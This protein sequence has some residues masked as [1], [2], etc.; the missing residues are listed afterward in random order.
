[1]ASIPPFVGIVCTHQ[2]VLGTGFVVD[3]EGKLVVTAA[4]VV[5]G[6]IGANEKLFFQLFGN[7][8]RYEIDQVAAHSATDIALLETLRPIPIDSSSLKLVTEVRP[9][10]DVWIVGYTEEGQLQRD[11]KSA[12]GKFMGPTM[13]DGVEFFEVE[14]KA[15]YKGMSGAPVMVGSNVIGVQTDR[16]S[17]R[18]FAGAL[19]VPISYVATLDERIQTKRTKY[20]QRLI[21]RLGNQQRKLFGFVECF[22]TVAQL[23]AEKSEPKSVFD[24]V[25]EQEK[26]LLVGPAGSGKSTILRE[27]AIRVAL[28]ALKDPQHGVPVFVDLYH[29]ETSPHSFDKFLQ[30]ILE[31]ESLLRPGDDLS[32]AELLAER[33]FYLFLDT[34]DELSSPRIRLLLDWVDK[35]DARLVLTSR[36]YQFPGLAT[37][38][39]PVA[40]LQPLNL[41]TVFEFAKSFFGD[42]NLA[43]DF[44]TSLGAAKSRY[45]SW[46][47]LNTELAGNPFYLS[48]VMESH[49]QDPH[50]SLKATYGQEFTQ[51]SVF[52]TIFKQ[53]WHAPRVVQRLSV[54]RS[55]LKKY[56]DPYKVIHLLSSISEYVQRNALE[57][58]V[59]EK[60]LGAEML[61]VLDESNIL[62]LDPSDNTYKFPHLLFVDFLRASSADLDGIDDYLQ[63]YEYHQ[64]LILLAT[65]GEREREVIQTAF[66]RALGENSRVTD[67]FGRDWI[68]DALGDIGDERAIDAIMNVQ[69]QSETQDYDRS[70]HDRSIAIAKIANRLADQNPHKRRAIQWLQ[71]RTASV[72]SWPVDINGDILYELGF[73][74]GP[75]GDYLEAAEAL[76]YIRSPEALDAILEVLDLSARYLHDEPSS[77]GWLRENW[78]AQ[79]I[80]N[81]GGWTVPRLIEAV[82]SDH[83]D[84]STT[85]ALAIRKL[86]RAADAT[87]LG[88]VLI[89][90]PHATVRA[91]IAAA[92]SERRSP[93]AVPYLC[94]AI[95][96]EGYWAMGG[97]LFGPPSFRFVADYVAG[98]LAE[99]GTPECKATLQENQYDESGEWT[100]QLLVSRLEDIRL[101]S[102]T[103]QPWVKLQIAGNL[104]ARDRIDL[105]L[106]RLGHVERQISPG[107]PIMCPIAS[108][109]ARRFNLSR[110]SGTES[111]QLEDYRDITADLIDFVETS[112]DTIS[113]TWALVVLGMV[114]NDSAHEFLNQ[115]L[116]KDRA[117]LA[118]EGAAYGLGCYLARKLRSLEVSQIQDVCDLLCATLVQSMGLAYGGVGHGLSRI[119]SAC[120]ATSVNT[121]TQRV[122]SSLLQRIETG[123]GPASRAA[124]DA[125]EV[126]CVE[127]EGFIDETVRTLLDASPSYH[128]KLGD[129]DYAENQRKEGTPNLARW[130]DYDNTLNI[131]ERALEAKLDP[132]AWW[133]SQYTEDDWRHLG[134]GDGHLY[135]R[136][137]KLM[138]VKEDWS[139]AIETLYKSC[140]AIAGYNG[141]SDAEKSIYLHSM[142]EIG[143]IA[144]RFLEVPE[145]AGHYHGAALEFAGN[146][147]R[148]NWTKELAQL[149]LHSMSNHQQTI[150]QFDRHDQVIAVGQVSLELL[151][152]AGTI[153]REAMADIYVNMH[154]SASALHDAETAM[155]AIQNAY[156]LLTRSPRRNFRA[157]TI[158][159]QAETLQAID[160]SADVEADAT[161]VRYYFKN[162][163]VPLMVAKADYI[164]AKSADHAG[165]PAEARRWYEDALAI[166]ATSDDSDA[167]TQRVVVL[168][169]LA[170]LH[171]AE[172]RYGLSSSL[173]D[174]SFSALERSG[175]VPSYVVHVIKSDHARLMHAIGHHDRAVDELLAV[176]RERAES[177][178]EP[179]YPNEVL[180]EI[181]AVPGCKMPAFIANNLVDAVK[182]A[183]DG[184]VSAF[185]VELHLMTAMFALDETEQHAEREF[186]RALLG[187]LRR[188][189]IDLSEDN[190]FR[191]YLLRVVATLR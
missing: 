187:I 137:G 64:A 33:R 172:G 176:I 127:N 99:I 72:S 68:F 16:V 103:Q 105:L 60:L 175:Q 89:S 39:V 147:T 54:S 38:P 136:I 31:Q 79:Y 118:L 14:I 71:S 69:P 102:T 142:L 32:L 22:P 145:V 123:I 148:Q 181:D 21:H 100:D 108:Q 182:L 185:A 74:F 6:A 160:P 11:Y 104:A 174:D 150:R 29:W 155:D 18:G 81:L 106:P 149:F 178:M 139:N 73:P 43:D 3:P 75:F 116:S 26:I 12:Q 5:N 165:N 119:V 169:Q 4:H 27:L 113:V 114:G 140:S 189:E 85:I 96:D 57:E 50:Q 10:D 154:Q 131:Y 47:N 128:S 134:C 163:G 7:T 62:T 141:P 95:K 191:P 91:Y 111:P 23:R 184:A 63:R 87:Q 65:R 1:M 101:D 179:G 67:V 92:L 129:S 158:L 56:H 143:N 9:S 173:F 156:V 8:N 135:H 132:T 51:W 168:H 161:E 61:E 44:V 82:Y 93:E 152:W 167:A 25:D 171:Q 40:S 15:V 170:L 110:S 183:L 153:D 109:L 52:E 66:L 159:A 133:R 117:Q 46:F 124:L 186:V 19:V 144:A 84:V 34:I 146:L 48:S 58:S 55:L 37:F 94:A 121:I 151:D 86:N 49:R 20:L 126:V 80:S 77:G 42:A 13:K 166:L 122:K 45:D 112:S 177:G 190:P 120:L 130:V 36:D 164:L 41:R 97:G 17:D 76:S 35:V 188:D 70:S 2:K 107:F 59:A 157:S 88:K 83:P 30:E 28:S 90:H 53:L 24:L 98:A 115:Y 162:L 125:L 138:I 78:F 180:S